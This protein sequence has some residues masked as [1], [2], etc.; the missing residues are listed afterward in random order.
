MPLKPVVFVPGFPASEL[1]QRSKN[2]TI[3]PPALA[4]L[5]DAEKKKK[6]IRLL[7]GPDD[8][9]GDIVAGEPIRGVLGIAK[10]AQS[11]YDVMREYGYTTQDGSLL[12]P[13]GWDWR[14]AV[15]ATAVQ[16]RFLGKGEA[17]GL[18]VFGKKLIG[19]N[20]SEVR[21]IMTRCQAG[22]D[23]CPP[24]PQKT[25]L[26]GADGKDLNLFV[27]ASQKQIGPL[28]E[29]AWIRRPSAR[30]STRS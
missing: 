18:I 1:R 19:L 7:S 27:N 10:Q 13:V 14:K 23:L 24:D 8:P 11:L 25:K 30:S 15:D 5:L 22:Y 2:R 12:A 26:Q 21:E 20:A 16:V 3:F 28:V 9:P 6:V 29:T 17:F 4:D